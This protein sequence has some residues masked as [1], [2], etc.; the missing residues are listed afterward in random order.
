[1]TTPQR[2]PDAFLPSRPGSDLTA[3]ARGE[4]ARLPLARKLTACR[5]LDASM[6]RSSST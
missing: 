6:I 2:F 5:S 1:M 3:W 4:A